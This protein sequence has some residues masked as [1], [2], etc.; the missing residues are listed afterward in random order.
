M[1]GTVLFWAVLSISVPSRLLGVLLTVKRPPGSSTS[2][3]LLSA[4]LAAMPIRPFV[5]LLVAWSTLDHSVSHRPRGVVLAPSW[6]FSSL[7]VAVALLAAQRL[8]GYLA[9]SWL[10]GTLLVT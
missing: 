5:A 7:L 6:L 9:L 3:S 1:P 10:P 4:L 8:P 2:S